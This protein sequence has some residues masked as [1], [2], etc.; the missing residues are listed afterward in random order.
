MSVNARGSE[1]VLRLREQRGSNEG[2]HPLPGAQLACV[3][4]PIDPSPTFRYVRAYVP[5]APDDTGDLAG[6]LRC[7]GECPPQGRPDIVV[8]PLQLV[9]PLLLVR[10][11]QVWLGPPHESPEELGVRPPDVVPVP[12]FL[13]RLCSEA[14]D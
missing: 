4:H 6:E 3:K 14:P 8:V 12:G 13:Q 9:E 5:E 11:N 7:V 10:P 1:I 2:A